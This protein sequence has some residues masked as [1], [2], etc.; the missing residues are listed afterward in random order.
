MPTGELGRELVSRREQMSW[1]WS[2]V[3]DGREALNTALG[4]LRVGWAGLLPFPQQWLPSGVT[5]PGVSWDPSWAFS[6]AE[7][8]SKLAPCFF[9]FSWLTLRIGM[10]SEGSQGTET[11]LEGSLSPSVL[12]PS[13]YSDPQEST[14]GGKFRGLSGLLRTLKPRDLPGLHSESAME[15]ES[16]AT[17]DPMAA[18]SVR[19]H[20]LSSYCVPAPSL[21]GQSRQG[22]REQG[23]DRA[24]TWQGSRK[25]A[26]RRWDAALRRCVKLC[27][28]EGV[29]GGVGT[30]SVCVWHGCVCYEGVNWSDD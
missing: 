3:E 16:P 14:L 2:A 1:G 20:L 24:H 8:C 19:E 30:P 6:L 22:H 21:I 13:S 12:V 9:F 26:W 4:P 5:D 15:L 29:R 25:A 10:C 28:P 18:F 23:S 11:L 27:K 17:T 7:V